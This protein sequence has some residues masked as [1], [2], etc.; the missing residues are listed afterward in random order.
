MSDSNQEFFQFD[1]EE[2]EASRPPQAVGLVFHSDGRASLSA[3]QRE[4]NLLMAR[5]E[6]ERAEVGREQRR[7]DQCLDECVRELIPIEQKIQRQR[8]NIA[9]RIREVLKSIKFS[10]RRR[11]ALKQMLHQKVGELLQN[12]SGFSESEI[13][14]LEE[15]AR[16]TSPFASEAEQREAESSEFQMLREEIEGLARAAGVDIDLDDLDPHED[17]MEFQAKV[18]ERIQAAAEALQNPSHPGKKKP[19]KPTKAQL[20]KER[21]QREVEEAKSRDLK[22]L[23]KQLAKALHPDLESDPELKR[24]KEEWMKRLTTA[25]AAGDLRELLR[26]EMEWLGEEASNLSSASDE[27]LRVYCLILK[28][29]IAETRRQVLDLVNQGKYFVIHRFLGPRLPTP[30]NVGLAKKHLSAEL[31]STKK[32]LALINVPDAEARRAFNNWTDSYANSLWNR[33]NIF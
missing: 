8:L 19:R 12:P 4:F 1:F 23:Y 33:Q 7:L 27:K 5:L 21:R 32:V 25:H 9:L 18:F 13:E 22:S 24:H 28:E 3:T 2:S 29:Q 6:K 31:T 17:P 15:I 30:R 16:E 14:T 20:E 26:I 11:E 10:R